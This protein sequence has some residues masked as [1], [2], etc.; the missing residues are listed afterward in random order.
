MT[1]P[2]INVIPESLLDVMLCRNNLC[3]CCSKSGSLCDV[4]LGCTNIW[5]QY[6][7]RLIQLVDSVMF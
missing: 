6:D 7:H 5:L 4:T 3:S 2:Q 1:Q